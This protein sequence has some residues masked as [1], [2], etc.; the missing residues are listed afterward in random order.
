MTRLVARRDALTVMLL[1]ALPGCTDRTPTVSATSPV[2]INWYAST[3]TNRDQEPRQPLIDAFQK[4]YPSIS[5]ELVSTPTNTNEVREMLDDKISGPQNNETPDVYLG[6]IIWPAEF[7]RKGLARP[8]NGLFEP[9]SIFWSRFPLELVAAA[10]YGGK[11]YAAP[12]YVDQGVLLYR[13][14]LLAEE[15]LPNPPT[16]WGELAEAARVLLAKGKVEQGFVWQGAEYE[17]L[18]CVWTEFTAS[19]RKSENTRAPGQADT[20]PQVDTP[21]A[22]TAL[23]FMRSLLTTGVS[24]STVTRS[25]EAQTAQ[26]F[27]SG[28][29]AFQRAWN[30]AYFDAKLS[31]SRVHGKV[32]VAALPK[33]QGVPG[34]GASTIGGWSLYINP[35]TRHLPQAVDF[36]DWMT[37]PPAQLTLAQ[38]SVIP[39][40]EKARQ[41]RLVQDNPVLAASTGSR[42]VRRPSA[43]PEYGRVS[44]VI[45]SQLHRALLGSVTP[46]AALREAQ[47]QI[48]LILG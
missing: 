3:T 26:A 37:A 5:V 19:A 38:Y 17:G 31:D 25:R 8:L 15:N 42:Q 6:D 21:E 4:A 33:F 23:T 27:E 14:D 32:G 20:R 29:A 36:I 2:T 22:R 34:P 40:N 11:T 41:D 30:S 43:N 35:R 16:T 18:T 1:A 12:F 13:E 46:Q 44:Q 24:P 47:R 48:D 39:T 10:T 28:Q 45:F 9:E 7:A